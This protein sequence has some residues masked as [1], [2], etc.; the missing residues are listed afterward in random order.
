[1]AYRWER[2]FLKVK[3]QRNLSSTGKSKAGAGAIVRLAGSE[4]F[5]GKLVEKPEFDTEVE[6]TIVKVWPGR[7]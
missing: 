1:M 3:L 6:R 7:C 4:V 2:S 5:E